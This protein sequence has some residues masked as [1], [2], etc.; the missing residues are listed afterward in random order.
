[1]HRSK[2]SFRT[3]ACTSCLKRNCVVPGFVPL[4]STDGQPTNSG[5]QDSGPRHVLGIAFDTSADVNEYKNC[6]KHETKPTLA[7]QG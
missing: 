5:I 2:T 1:M 7:P 4:C 6:E 3:S